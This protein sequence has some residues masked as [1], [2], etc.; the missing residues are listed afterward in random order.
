[1]NNPLRVAS[2]T[3]ALLLL[4]TGN[5][6]QGAH[7]DERLGFEVRTPRKWK[8]IPIR[9]DESWIVGKY[10]AAKAERSQDPETGLQLSHT[11]ELLIVAFLDPDEEDAPKQETRGG[12]VY[13]DYQDFLRANY[14]QGFFIAGEKQ[15]THK[16]LEVTVLDI[17][18]SGEARIS[19]KRITTWLYSVEIGTIAVA[20]EVMQASYKDHR[21][22]IDKVMKSFKVIPRT[23]RIKLGVRDGSFLSSVELD[24]LT[25]ADRREHKI[26]AQRLE[27]ENMAQAMPKG[28]DAMEIDEV[29]V[30]THAGKKYTKDVVNHVNNL[31]TW[32]DGALPS[33]GPDE[34]ARPPLVRICKDE[35]EEKAFREGSGTYSVRGTHLVTHEG[36]RA[37]TWEW[38]YVGSRTLMVWFQERDAELYTA[39]PRWLAVGLNEV[40]RSA[41]SKRSKLDFRVGDTEKMFREDLPKASEM[42]SLSQLF[43]LSREEFNA[44]GKRKDWKP[45]FQAVAAT[46]FFVNSNSKKNREILDSYL[47]NLRKALDEFEAKDREEE[48]LVAP[49]NEEEENAYFEAR[50]KLIEKRERALLDRAFEL[51]FG[52]W[53]KG[54]WMKLQRTFGRA[55]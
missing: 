43:S 46:R 17:E 28:W 8:Q 2:A 39:L 53:D 48:K 50:L 47:V 1:M 3:L 35:A 22:S 51:T 34:H 4:A 5:L 18:V 54:K 37:A 27:W 40:A 12:N 33:V 16:G 15:I 42:M 31:R 14:S 55:L 9:P 44:H 32:L 29:F 7:K 38:E 30:I 45:W 10:Q 11:P 49:T 25:P 21:S 19:A 24:K 52:S 20:Y 13:N 36:S 6:A 23:K 26:E 41:V